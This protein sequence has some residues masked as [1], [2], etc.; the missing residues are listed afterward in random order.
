MSHKITDRK[1]AIVNFIRKYILAITGVVAALFGMSGTIVGSYIGIIPELQRN[2]S[3]YLK[4]INSKDYPFI[5][6]GIIAE[7]G[8]EVQ[9][10]VEGSDTFWNCGKGFISPDGLFGSKMAG[11]IFPAANL[12]ELVAFLQEGVFIRIGSYEKF[13]ADYSGEL[14]LGANDSPDYYFDNEG[15][16]T[17]KVII[18]K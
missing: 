14:H 10:I 5:N 17:I 1:K 8:N 15:I 6:T 11:Y 18:R 12:C 7:K 3:V 13:I 2:E 16:I 9:I 4:Q